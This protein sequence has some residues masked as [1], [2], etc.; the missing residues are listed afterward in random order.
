MKDPKLTAMPRIIRNEPVPWWFWLLPFLAIIYGVC[1]FRFVPL[2][3]E[4]PS[5][6]SNRIVIIPVFLP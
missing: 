2:P 6:K 5:E 4:Q 3:A 1:V